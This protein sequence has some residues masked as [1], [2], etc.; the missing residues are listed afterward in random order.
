MRS[1][2]RGRVRRVFPGANTPHGFHSFYEDIIGPEANRVIILKGGPGVGKSTFIKKMG[3]RLLDMGYDVEYECCSSDNDSVDGLVVRDLGL[4]MIDGTSPHV[5]DPRAP[6]AVDEIL[7]LGVFWDERLL[8]GSR[9]EILEASLE[10]SRHFERAFRYLSEARVIHDDWEA[11]YTEALDFGAV[12][13]AAAEVVRD[14]LQGMPVSPSPGRRRRL[15]ASAIS[16]DGPVH[17]LDTIMGRLER[18]YVVKAEPGCGKSTLV[19]KVGE[20]AIERGL[21]T[22][23]YHC[24]LDPSKVDHIVIP[25]LSVAVT[26]A[27]WPH[28]LEASGSL[29]RTIDLNAAVDARVTARYRDV[30][31][32]ATRRF[33]EAFRRA[34]DSLNRAKRAHDEMQ[35]YYV[36]AMDFQAVDRAAERTFARILELEREIAE[37]SA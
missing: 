18:R 23:F 21:D 30:I 29:D 6:G 9:R 16:P 31:A 10:V 32:D 13:C 28:D 14:V 34:T 15:F 11:C 5:V 12:N 19:R 2:G 1:Q 24:P 26:S 35:S 27:A 33:H 7:D 4:A 25:A 20:A 36:R 37:A 22:E 17:H 3:Q 8:K